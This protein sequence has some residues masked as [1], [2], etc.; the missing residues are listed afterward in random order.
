MIAEAAFAQVR[1]A[2]ALDRFAGLF[3]IGNVK[4][5]HKYFPKRAL[6]EETGPYVRNRLVC[7][8][9]KATVG[10]GE[11]A[12]D[13]FATGWRATG[14]MVVTYVHTAL[15]TG[16]PPDPPF[17]L[18]FCLLVV[19]SGRMGIQFPVNPPQKWDSI[20]PKTDP[21]VP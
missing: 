17:L 9:K 14:K 11:E 15:L 1:A 19:R 20:L 13:V 2:V 21:G 3:F 10:T 5:C 4:A 18:P 16:V 7:L 8:T 12:V 6:K